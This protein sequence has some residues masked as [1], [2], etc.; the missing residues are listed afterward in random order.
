[1]AGVSTEEIKRFQTLQKRE[2]EMEEAEALLSDLQIKLK[3]ASAKLYENIV[4]PLV[5]Y[6]GT[7][8]VLPDTLHFELL[9]YESLSERFPNL[10]LTKSDLNKQ[11]FV[12]GQNLI[13]VYP[14]N[15]FYTVA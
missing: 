9:D 4:C 10:K 7:T 8:G 12:M 5:F 11:F 2:L 3:Q 6:I 14:M 1:M 15:E 13:S